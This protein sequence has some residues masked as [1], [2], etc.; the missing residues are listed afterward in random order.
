MALDRETVDKLASLGYVGAT[1][2][3][4]PRAPGQLLADPKDMIG[5]FNRLR[6]A[7]SA[8]RDRRFPD[9]LPVLQDVLHEDPKNAF[10]TLV[11]GSAYLGMEQ[12]TRAIQQFQRYLQLVPTSAY[13]HQW[14]AICHIRLG[15][16]DAALEEAERRWRS[17]PG[18]RTHGCCAPAS[19]RARTVPTRR[20]PS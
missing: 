19:W 10:A 11:L 13:A 20:S 5:L 9:A 15:Q 4:A 8:V 17:I 6:R 1:A 2:E 7:N 12:Y 3:P 14:I 16:Q 18:F